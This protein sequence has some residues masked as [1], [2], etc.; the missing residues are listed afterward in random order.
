[1]TRIWAISDLHIGYKANREALLELPSHPQDMVLLVGDIGETLEQLRYCLDVF[2]ERF[3]AVVWVP[4]N[5][6]LWTHRSCESKLRG[7][8][9]YHRLVRLC[10]ARGVITPECPYRPI[11]GHPGLWLVPLFV[12]ID[13]SMGPQGM[14]PDQARKWAWEE[15]IV[16]TDERLWHPDPYPD[17]QS[18]C[19]ARVQSTERRMEA[20][21][22]PEARTLLVGH[23]PLRRD[24]VRLPQR[25][26]RFTPWCGTR[27]TEQ[28]H[29]RFRAQVVVSGHLHMR[30]TDWRDGVRFEEVALGYPRHWHQGVGVSSYV[31]QILPGP[32][33]PESG[34]GGPI[35]HRYGSA[36]P[37]PEMGS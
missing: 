16:S 25:V 36:P 33:A 32:A 18:W 27:L 14:D 22:P 5:H 13:Y 17:L 7:R 24:L 20:E 30:A 11:E 19:A 34:S 12:G 2:Q 29:R 37:P 21:L 15:H 3:G 1:M 8:A 4:G 23:W 28:W 6:E 10:Q 35:W 9:R 31:R 26:A